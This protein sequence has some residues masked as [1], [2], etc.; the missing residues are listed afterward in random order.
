MHF[1][2][3]FLIVLLLPIKVFGQA[4]AS[5]DTLVIVGSNPANQTPQ[6]M[7]SGS[8]ETSGGIALPN[9][10]IKVKNQWKGTSTDDNGNY[11]MKMEPGRYSLMVLHVGMDTLDVD[12]IMVESGSLKFVMNESLVS[13]DEIIISGSK[14]SDNFEENI[15]GVERV[16]LSEIMKMPAFL[17][18]A[19]V[20]NSITFLPGVSRAGDGASG[21]NVRGGRADQNLILFNQAPLFNSSH[22]LG[23]FSVFN[24]DIIQG[25]TL[26]KGHIPVNYGG[27]IS[28]VLDISERAPD[29]EEFKIKASISNVIA[30]ATLDIPLK[31][32]KTSILLA[33]RISY[34]DW[35]L[36]QM[37]DPVL[38][39]SSAGFY[40]VNASIFHKEKDHLI[41]ASFFRT[42]DNFQYS[43]EFGFEWSNTTA[44]VGW[45][46]LIDE[47]WNNDLKASYNNYDADFLD[48]QGAEAGTLKNG[49]KYFQF[50]D[51]VSFEINN[52]HI[53]LGGVEYINYQLKPER[54]QP[55]SENSSLRSDEVEKGQGHQIDFFLSDE[56]TI[57]ERF[58]SSIGFRV[59][60]FIRTGPDQIYIYDTI[61]PALATEITDTLVFENGE[62]IADYHGFEPRISFT[63]ILS[64]ENSIKLS[65]NRLYQYLQQISN[66][67]SATPTDFWLL[68]NNYILPQ[69]SNNYSLGYFQNFGFGKFEVSLEG[70]YRDQQNQ[71]VFVDLPDLILN[72]AIERELV[73]GKGRAYGVEFLIKKNLGRLTGWLSY[74]YSRA[75]Y[76]I[77]NQFSEELETEKWIPSP[78]DIPHQFSF[79]MNYKVGLKN[80]FSADFVYNSGRP[81]TGLS[82]AYILNGT[83]VPNFSDRNDFRMPS[84]FR[85][86]LSFTING[87]I[88]QQKKYKDRLQ[89]TLY[90]ITFRKNP[91]SIYF[92][93]P[94]N[95]KFPQA[96]KF[97]VLGTVFPS[98]TYSFEI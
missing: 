61:P 60:N 6:L 42:G 65:Y 63:Y 59:S 92:R 35:I 51:E 91:Y 87:F 89:L 23:F 90:N 76:F 41:S 19:D 74:T 7:L 71:I 58:K 5:S 38:R 93:T 27:R 36:N 24:S 96:Y 20:I 25:V 31:N 73:Q 54:I 47:R 46:Y 94:V 45:S 69:A 1:R 49:L 4:I 95:F 28:S 9:A 84:Y 75:E 70:F 32:Q 62:K 68:S 77:D 14:P 8:V 57:N 33:G 67:T 29:F 52:D 2:A 98:I 80:N 30:K 37:E 15:A 53:L 16:P 82:S 83:V 56:L 78:Y 22:V 3:V 18:E 79:L 44:N 97:S 11:E 66:T 10:N 86:D 48:L 88:G 85:L 26:Y 21:F 12:V 17:G 50:K 34:S 81:Y 13:L 40:D 39:N 72:P 55:N 64:K 43:N